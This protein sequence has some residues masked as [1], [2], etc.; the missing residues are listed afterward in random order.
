MIINIVT[1][2]EPQM[3]ERAS[4][5]HM[6]IQFLPT[7]IGMLVWVLIVICLIRLIRFLGNARNEMK[8]VRMELSKLAEEVHLLRRESKGRKEGD[9]SSG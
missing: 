9:S 8:L 2:V 4:P 5:T 3:V 7:L 6:Y 1:A